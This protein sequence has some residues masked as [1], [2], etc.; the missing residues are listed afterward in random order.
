[1]GRAGILPVHMNSKAP[2]F[3][4][5]PI[6]TPLFNYGSHTLHMESG[7]VFEAEKIL[8]TWQ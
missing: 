8:S 3:I 5:G 7:L 2:V 4:D 1:M 6:S